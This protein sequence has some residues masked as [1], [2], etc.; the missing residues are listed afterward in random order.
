MKDFRELSYFEL[1]ITL[2]ILSQSGLLIVP[3]H[4]FWESNIQGKVKLN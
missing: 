1:W 2:G 3:I 4:N